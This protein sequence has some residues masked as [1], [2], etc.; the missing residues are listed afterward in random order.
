MA[1]H[2]DAYIQRLKIRNLKGTLPPWAAQERVSSDPL[3]CLLFTTPRSGSHLTLG[4]AAASTVGQPCE[5]Q[6]S[7]SCSLLTWAGQHPACVCVS[8]SRVH[9]DPCVSH[10]VC[11][12]CPT[13]P[14]P[15][16]PVSCGCTC[17]CPARADHS[18]RQWGRSGGR[19]FYTT[20]HRPRGGGH[21]QWHWTEQVPEGPAPVG[22]P[23]PLGPHTNRGHCAGPGPGN[24]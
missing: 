8:V 13:C 10:L 7:H 2:S 11:P 5:H 22:P 23:V 3:C 9:H 24:R 1:A 6:R 12:V 19:Q 14:V 17:V 20:G 18:W 15:R 4:L 16:V 21:G